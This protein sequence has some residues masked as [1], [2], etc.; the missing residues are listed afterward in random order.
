MRRQFR[1]DRAEPPE[2]KPV[3]PPGGADNLRAGAPCGGGASRNNTVAAAGT[4]VRAAP[5]KI[6]KQG[7]METYEKTSF[8]GI[9]GGVPDADAA[10]RVGVCGR[11]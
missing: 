7:G 5:R 6:E 11:Q 3:P 1:P 2:E 9:D 8:V 10:P 4:A